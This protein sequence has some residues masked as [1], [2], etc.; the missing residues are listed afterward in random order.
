MKQV[1]DYYA[2]R[3]SHQERRCVIGASM[4]RNVSILKSVP[5]HSFERSGCLDHTL[6]SIDVHHVELLYFYLS[7]D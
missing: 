7:I 1:N 2:E 3:R 4:A 5:R 6:V